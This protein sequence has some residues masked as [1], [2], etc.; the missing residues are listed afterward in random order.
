MDFDKIIKHT[1][2]GNEVFNNK[3]PSDNILKNKFSYKKESKELF[4]LLPPWGGKLYYNFFPRKFLIKKGFSVLEYEFPKAILSSNW[5]FTLDHFNFIRKSVTKEIE[6]LKKVY[7]FQRIT[8]VGVSLGCVNACMCANNN[9]SIDEIFLIIPGHCLAESM[10]QG[11]STQQIRQEYEN[12]KISLK[13]LKNHWHTLAPENNITNLKSKKV[14][15]FLSKA[16]K[17]IPYYCGKKLF[18]KAKSK[19]YN[20]FYKI[21]NNLG[22]YL[23]ALQFHLS[24]KRFLFNK[25]KN[26]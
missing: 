26:A 22:H 14:S 9:K 6:K 20:L 11:I 8:I 21:N 12:Q 7:G 19:R 5:K 16:D 15:I 23:T 4:V 10:W 2:N 18:E 1:R 17:V 24:P 25:E 13:E 3:I